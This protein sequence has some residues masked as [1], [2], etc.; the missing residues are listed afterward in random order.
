MGGGGEG[1]SGRGTKPLLCDR[2]KYVD[3]DGDAGSTHRNKLQRKGRGSKGREEGE[4]GGTKPLLCEE[5]HRW[6]RT[7]LLTGRREEDDRGGGKGDRA[8]AL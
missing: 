5:V 2:S 6:T 1:E 4:E 7:D 3:E 8:V